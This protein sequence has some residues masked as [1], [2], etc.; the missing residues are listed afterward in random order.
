MAG[1]TGEANDAGAYAGIVYLP[2]HAGERLRPEPPK[3]NVDVIYLCSPNNPTGAAATRAAARGLGGLRAGRISS[4]ILFDAAYEAYISRSRHPAFD[5]RNPRRARMRHRVPQLLEERRL[6]RHALRLH[7]RAEDPAWPRRAGRIQAA[8][9]A[10]AAAHDHEVQRRELHRPARR[11]GALFAGRQ[12]A[13]RALIE[14]YMGNAK[15]LVAGAKAAGLKVY[16]GVNA[17]YIWVQ[18]PK[19]RD[20]L[21]G[22]RQDS[23]RSE[24][25]HHARQRLR[26]EGRRLFP[27]LRLQQ[28]RQCR[29]SRAQAAGVEVVSTAV[30]V[31]S[32]ETM[33]LLKLFALCYAALLAGCGST[34]PF[35][36]SRARQADPPGSQTCVLFTRTFI[37][38]FGDDLPEWTSKSYGNDV[39]V[40]THL[41]SKS[42]IFILT[43]QYKLSKEELERMGK[44]EFLRSMARK[45]MESAD[46]KVER[47][48]TFHVLE[49]T[50]VYKEGSKERKVR[51][52]YTW[53]GLT[54]IGRRWQTDNFRLDEKVRTSV[55]VA[56]LASD[57]I[58]APSGAVLHIIA[59][60]PT[61][62]SEHT[63]A[64]ITKR[65]TEFINALR[66]S[67]ACPLH[68]STQAMLCDG[69]LG[70]N[71]FDKL[72]AFAVSQRPAYFPIKCSITIWSSACVVAVGDQ[73]LRRLFVEGARL[74]GRDAGTCGGCWSGVPSQCSTLRGAE[75]MHVEADIFAVLAVAVA[76]EGAHLV[77][78]AA[79]V[80][81]A[82]R[83]C[84]GRY[85]RPFWSLRCSDHSLPKAHSEIDFVGGIEA[86]QDG[87]GRFNQAADAFRIAGQVAPARAR[88][89][90]WGCRR[91]PSARSAWV[92][93]RCGCS[94]RAPASCRWPRPDNRR[95]GEHS[96]LRGC[97]LPSRASQRTMR[98]VP[99]TL[100][101]S[102]QRSER[103]MA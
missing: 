16:G 94:D 35:G 46:G 80:R 17:P 87:V 5:L 40:V 23:E 61:N 19:R 70:G 91:D 74:V 37:G 67:H 18:T 29:G 96:S 41:P 4:I 86:G 75:G 11:R 44:A 90:W 20:E 10:L 73:L 22:V 84:P 25:R 7:R 81:A 45:I 63:I 54:Y 43:R 48:E 57:E 49:M 28:P 31:R 88:A 82:E 83:A 98:S 101:M 33:N 30:H 51:L 53:L 97:K 2:C 1:H 79:Q 27:H 102:M 32:H 26:L 65:I 9:S 85:F 8:A 55:W 76:F 77:E 15:V 52:P 95:S 62:A 59:M 68:A 66:C 3:E 36:H 21:A 103:S 38:K 93:W 42:E 72:T 99:R 56:D 69:E 71:P 58:A 64:R 39:A 14:H 6:H 89:R 34:A 92:R 24:C 12:G 60:I 13:G 50:Q 47:A 78:R 100:A